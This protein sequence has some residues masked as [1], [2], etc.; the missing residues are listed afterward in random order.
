MA[1]AGAKGFEKHNRASR[2]TGLLARME[3]RIPW[4]EFCALVEPHFPKAGNGRAPVDLG[5][6]LRM[7]CVVNWLNLADEACEAARYDTPVFR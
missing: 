7:Y 2:K 4:A 6:L 1:L 5:R 3:S